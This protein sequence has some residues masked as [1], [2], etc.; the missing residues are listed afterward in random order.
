MKWVDGILDV[1]WSLRLGLIVRVHDESESQASDY[2]ELI[3][4][5]T[6]DGKEREWFWQIRKL[7][8]LFSP[9]GDKRKHERNGEVKVR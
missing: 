2:G 5:S 9:L 7:L 1:D 3:G 6:D 4:K 8:L